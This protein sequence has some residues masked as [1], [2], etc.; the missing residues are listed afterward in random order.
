MRILWDHKRSKVVSTCYLHF[1]GA[2]V[3][4][5]QFCGDDGTT[6]PACSRSVGPSRIVGYYEGWAVD[7]PCHSFEPEHIPQGVYTHLN[8]AYATVDPV[9]FEVRPGSIRDPA[10]MRR[11][12][13]LRK[14]QPDLKVF[15]AIG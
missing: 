7:R 3:D 6:K 14:A 5:N 10:L 2:L 8:Y 9:T 4:P 15:V 1:L 13:R 12:I 11:L